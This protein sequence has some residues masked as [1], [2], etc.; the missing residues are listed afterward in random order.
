MLQNLKDTNP[1]R[2]WLDE[3]FQTNLDLVNGKQIVVRFEVNSRP[4]IF[5][6]ETVIKE[7]G[8]G[9]LADIKIAS[10]IAEVLNQKMDIVIDEV[11]RQCMWA[12]AVTNALSAK[13][14]RDAAIF[15]EE[16]IVSL[17]IF[18]PRATVVWAEWIDKVYRFI[19]TQDSLGLLG[20]QP[21]GL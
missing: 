2:V 9:M 18:E 3:R 11:A 13:D 1:Y 19:D 7:F 14:Y 20:M 8:D 4:Y 21:D 17:L 5:D 10:T 12:R 16:L 6:A 15:L